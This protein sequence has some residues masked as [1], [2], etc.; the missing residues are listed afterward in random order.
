M[1][2]G[3]GRFKEPAGGFWNQTDFRCI[4]KNVTKSMRVCCQNSICFESEL[5]PR[6][7]DEIIRPFEKIVPA[8][9]G[10][11]A[12]CHHRLKGMKVGL[13]LK[14]GAETLEHRDPY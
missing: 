5:P 6:F 10:V 14:E 1:L 13:S 11:A 2:V 9:A 12:R 7:I 4:L 8:L 3:N